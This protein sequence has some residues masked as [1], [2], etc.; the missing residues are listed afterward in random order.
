MVFL[1]DKT[2]QVKG[3]KYHFRGCLKFWFLQAEFWWP[4]AASWTRIGT[5][6]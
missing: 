4:W 2:V 3:K 1:C 6:E 5:V